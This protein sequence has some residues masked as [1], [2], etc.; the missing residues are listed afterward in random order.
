M[1]YTS[2]SCIETLFDSTV[3]GLGILGDEDVDLELALLGLEAADILFVF[4]FSF[5]CRLTNSGVAELLLNDAKLASN[6]APS[7]PEPDAAVLPL[8]L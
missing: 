8:T 7:S 4:L 5:S 2:L 1:M 6:P 3:G